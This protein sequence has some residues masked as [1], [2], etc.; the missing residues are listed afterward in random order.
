MATLTKDFVYL[1]FLKHIVC[2]AQMINASA[3]GVLRLQLKI[4]Y[5]DVIKSN[6]LRLLQQMR[7]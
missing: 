5:L 6:I 7:K 3:A 1:L 4:E 2:F